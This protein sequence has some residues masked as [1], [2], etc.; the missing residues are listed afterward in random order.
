[1][2]K[3]PDTTTKLRTYLRG[4]T[5]QPG[6]RLPGE[7]D[8]AGILHVGRTG[9]RP[10][11]AAMEAE[12]YLERRPQSGTFLTSVPPA[13]AQGQRVTLIAPFNGSTK[14]EQHHQIEWMYRVAVAFERF[15]TAAG[16][17]ITV[18]DQSPY[19]EEVC[20]VKTMA[21]DAAKSGAQSVVLLHPTGTR[22]KIAHTLT[23]LHDQGVYP[24][25][26]SAR[27]YPGMVSQVYFDSGWGA[28]LATRHL[29]QKAHR[30]IGFAGGASGHDWLQDRLSG[31]QSAL[32]AAGIN[33]RDE[34]V[35]LAEDGERVP[36]AADG[37]R[38]FHAWQKLPDPIR[39]TA[40]VA[41]N[42]VIA[43][44]MLQAAREANVSVPEAFSLIG[45]DNDPDAMLAGLTTVERPTDTLG[46]AAARIVAEH[47]TDRND[48]DAVSVRL[49]PILIERRTV[50]SLH[51]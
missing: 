46:E 14:V 1:M 10:A 15:G 21:L 9:L 18:M 17:R 5:L 38:A 39:P 45:F 24:V 25:I 22:A 16:L 26:L 41:A 50:S 20:S 12:G 23:L 13:A 47:F 29:L 7:R 42:D 31:Y 49:R 6:D 3:Q 30:N 36:D 32:E 8:L 33:P 35:W 4:G 34:W 40:I 44:G 28:Y 37:E 19:S 11:L 2:R 51:P 48:K 43:L 27:T